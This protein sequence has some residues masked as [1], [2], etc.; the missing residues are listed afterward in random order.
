MSNI[1]D[2]VMES[3]FNN[4][5]ESADN[6]LRGADEEKLRKLA[7]VQHLPDAASSQYQKNIVGGATKMLGNQY[8]G[9]EIDPKISNKLKNKVADKFNTIMGEKIL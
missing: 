8:S 6:I 9:V 5:E 2:L 4:S 3:L 7:R 1:N